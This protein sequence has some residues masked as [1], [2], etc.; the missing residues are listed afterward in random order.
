MAR[1]FLVLLLASLLAAPS[2]AADWTKPHPHKGTLQPFAG[3]PPP[4]K[5]SDGER[6]K[7][8]TGKPVFRQMEDAAGTGGRGMAVFYV[9]APRT[10][11]WSVIADFKSYPKWIDDVKET[12]VYGK[13][14]SEAA[15]QTVDVF[16]KIGRMGVSVEYFIRHVFHH[17]AHWMTWTL[18][19]GK[20]SDIDDSVGFWRVTPMAGEPQRSIVEYSVDLKVKGWV[21]GFIKDALLDS[22][23]KAATRWVKV[24]S[25][26][27][28]A[29]APAVQA[30]P[31]PPG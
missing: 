30:A 7:L 24:Q 18:D 8:A 21:P 10:T 29:A 25:E 9:D 19:Y 13:Q 12:K 23:L 4:L 11:V 5:L 17:D 3:E 1:P 16:M 15:V 2:I 27:R 20:E 22:G 6:A 31:P 26:A 28:A 14:G